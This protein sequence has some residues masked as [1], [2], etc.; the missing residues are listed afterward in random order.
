MKLHHLL[1]FV[2]LIA[3]ALMAATHKGPFNNLPGSAPQPKPGGGSYRNVTWDG[4]LLI[5]WGDGDY[6]GGILHHPDCP[7]GKAH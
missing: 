4:H 3:V 6:S 7:C 2:G 5:E 1:I